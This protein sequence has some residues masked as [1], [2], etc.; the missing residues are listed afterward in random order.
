MDQLVMWGFVINPYDPCVVNKVVNGSQF[1]IMWHVDNL[2]M[3]H[4]DHRVLDAFVL[5]T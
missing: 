5:V 2:K 3:S 1:T 4:I